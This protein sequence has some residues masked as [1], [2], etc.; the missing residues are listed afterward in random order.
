MTPSWNGRKAFLASYE[1]DE[2]DGKNDWYDFLK[3]HDWCLVG[4]PEEVTDKLKRFEA[5]LGMEHLI[6]YWAMPGVNFEQM[7]A[8]VK[9]FADKVMPNF[10]D[11]EPTDVVAPPL[12]DAAV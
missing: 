8:S 9:L 6:L 7:T 3:E 11:A 12:V 4:T 5:E 10:S 1:E 2:D